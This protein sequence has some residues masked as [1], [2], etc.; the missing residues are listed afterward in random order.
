MTAYMTAAQLLLECLTDALNERPS[1]PPPDKIML[2]AGEEVRAMLGTTVDECCTG[3]AWVRIVGT[4]PNPAF[5]TAAQCIGV[6]RLVTLEM[7]VMRCAPQS[8]TSTVPSATQWG[9]AALQ[10]DSDLDAME[11]ALCCLR[12]TLS[13]MDT[14]PRLGGDGYRPFGPDGNC[15]GGIMQIELEVSCGCQA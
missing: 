6:G 14:P 8:S 2:R 7:G 15:L 10:L 1:P 4:A 13:A 5:D 9:A 11:A 3:L 12:E